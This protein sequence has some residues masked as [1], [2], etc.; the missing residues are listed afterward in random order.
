ML[1][2]IANDD[3]DKTTDDSCDDTNEEMQIEKQKQMGLRD[4]I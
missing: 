1:G 3:N 2:Q 4:K